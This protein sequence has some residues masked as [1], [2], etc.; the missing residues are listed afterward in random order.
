MAAPPAIAWLRAV[1]D[2]LRQVTR[3][4]RAECTREGR[5]PS[6]PASVSPA[7]RPPRRSQAYRPRTG[8][9]SA[10]GSR[11]A[12]G[13]PPT[14]LHRDGFALPP[15]QWAHEGLIQSVMPDTAGARRVVGAR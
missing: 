2:A 6:A 1:M 11:G 13:K 5:G 3:A 10:M 12:G 14:P 9:T 4:L 7:S 8:G 15:R